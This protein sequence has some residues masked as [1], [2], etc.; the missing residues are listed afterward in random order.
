MDEIKQQRIRVGT[1]E[2]YWSSEYKSLLNYWQIK[3]ALVS[4]SHKQLFVDVEDFPKDQKVR[5]MDIMTYINH[6][7]RL[8]WLKER[9]TCCLRRG[10]GKIWR[11]SLSIEQEK[12]I[13]LQIARRLGKVRKMIAWANQLDQ[14]KQIEQAFQIRLPSFFRQLYIYAAD[15]FGPNGGLLPL[16]SEDK[17]KTTVLSLNQAIQ[18]QNIHDPFW[19]FPKELLLF[20]DWGNEIY[21]GINC[22]STVETVWVWDQNQVLL[23]GTQQSGLWQHTQDMIAWLEV[24]VEE[25]AEGAALF[26]HMYRVKNEK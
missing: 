5:V 13:I 10:R 15:G 26:K 3:I 8:G 23:H 16:L 4:A 24:W 2:F 22:E 11:T 9:A 21:S 6:S 18:A 1:H 17:S 20:L 19:K 7:F 12:E 14:L 25:D